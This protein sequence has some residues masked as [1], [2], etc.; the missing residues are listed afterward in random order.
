MQGGL[1]ERQARRLQVE[2]VVLEQRLLQQDLRARVQKRLQRERAV[3]QVSPVTLSV[4]ARRCAV[5]ATFSFDNRGYSEVL[6]RRCDLSAER[7]NNTT[8]RNNPKRVG[9]R[10]K[11]D[12]AQVEMRQ[13]AERN[14]GIPVLLLQPQVVRRRPIRQQVKS[15]VHW[16]VIRAFRVTARVVLLPALHLAER[17]RRVCHRTRRAREHQQW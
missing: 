11:Q 2:Q 13:A 14:P 9:R 12:A 15:L 6:V 16:V 10:V 1:W 5:Q 7:W 8:A 4:Q 3:L 17:M